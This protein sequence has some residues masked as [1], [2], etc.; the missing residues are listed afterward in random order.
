VKNWTLHLQQLLDIPDSDVP[1]PY[2]DLLC[3]SV[4][5]YRRGSVTYRENLASATHGI[6][7]SKGSPYH[8]Q[9][10]FAT[11]AVSSEDPD[12]QVAVELNASEVLTPL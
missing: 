4:P 8:G 1:V 2:V 12:T 3:C 10:E 11:S 5:G 6:F 9:E 7:P